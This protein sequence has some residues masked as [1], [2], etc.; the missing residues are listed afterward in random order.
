MQLSVVDAQEKIPGSFWGDPEAGLIKNTLYVRSDTPF[1]SILHESCHYV[2]MRETRR[3]SL[4]TNALGKTKGDYSEE[5]AVCYLQC[6]IAD[7]FS[8]YSCKQLFS[9]M[10]AWGYNFRLGS[11]QQW[12][13]R[14]ANDAK[15]WLLR[16]GLIDNDLNYLYNLRR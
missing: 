10:D 1:H 11:A 16:N 9:D 4:H 14:D 2:C 6:L 7:T 5:D 8:F 12:F 3:Q 13:E 15:E